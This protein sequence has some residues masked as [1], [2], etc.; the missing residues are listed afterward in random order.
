MSGI[1][2]VPAIHRPCETQDVDRT[3]VIDE[4]TKLVA[5]KVFDLLKGND[6]LI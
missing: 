4:R 3:L 5:K 1:S 2:R 6:R